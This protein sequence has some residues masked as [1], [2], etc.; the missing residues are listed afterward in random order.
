MIKLPLK[1]SKMLNV[2]LT[3]KQIMD[4]IKWVKKRQDL[5]RIDRRKHKLYSLTLELQDCILANKFD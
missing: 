1:Y 3:Q 2:N 4:L 5:E